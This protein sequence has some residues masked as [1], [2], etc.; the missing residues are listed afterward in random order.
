MAEK[1]T[2]S[3]NGQ[4]YVQNLPLGI[5]TFIELISKL[6]TGPAHSY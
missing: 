5:G 1:S 3:P 4:L 2:S 6:M